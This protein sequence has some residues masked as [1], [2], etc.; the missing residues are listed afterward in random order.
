ML[1]PV[2]AKLTLKGATPEVEGVA[3]KL[4]HDG[5]VVLVAICVGTGVS[6]GNIIG[7]GVGVSVI[8][9]ETVEVG[10]IE[11]MGDGVG[12]GSEEVIVMFAGEDEES[13]WLVLEAPKTCVC[14]PNEISVGAVSVAAWETKFKVPM[15]T[16]FCIICPFCPTESVTEMVPFP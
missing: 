7:V 13:S 15:F 5:G 6:V 12:V 4:E 14:V 10:A 3:V 1:E 8:R 9:A 2:T 11:G 16:G